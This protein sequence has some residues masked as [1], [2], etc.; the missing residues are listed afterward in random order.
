MAKNI[1]G[2][3][4]TLNEEKHIQACIESLQ[5]VC[6]EV[7]VVDSLST[8][9]TVSIAEEC[10][11]RIIKQTYL[12]DGPQKAF[13]VPYAANDWI[14]SLDAD[15]RLD[16]DLVN[17][18]M[19]LDL[20]RDDTAYAFK[21][22]NYVGDHWIKAAGFYPDYVTRLYNRKTSGY[23]DKKAH[24]KVKAPRIKKVRAHILHYTYHDYS[25]WMERLNWLTTRDA[26]AYYQKGKKQS[27]LRPFFSATG[28]FIRKFFIK[29]GIF[30]GVDGMT[31][32][33]TTVMRAYMKYIKLNEMHEEA[34]KTAAKK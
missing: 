28:A 17:E 21:R 9:C 22:K 3:I 26:W 30:Q 8:D 20:T 7:I 23:L 5:R 16:D 24:S 19:R 13:G 18:L 32:T 4:I 15:E 10:G 27:A 11:A 34:K 14:L 33:L 1:T 25:H 6:H 12:G 2:I 29:G 31:V